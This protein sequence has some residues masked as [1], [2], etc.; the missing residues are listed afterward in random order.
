MLYYFEHKKVCHSLKVAL[1][2]MMYN[3]VSEWDSFQSY[4]KA[5]SSFLFYSHYVSIFYPNDIITT[6]THKYRLR[7]GDKVFICYRSSK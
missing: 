1:L 2:F 4:I 3:T 6:V 5:R 7:T